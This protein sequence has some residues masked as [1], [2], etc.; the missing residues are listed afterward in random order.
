MSKTI[1][2]MSS[3]CTMHFK[4]A[5]VAFLV[6]HVFLLA[7]GASR[8]GDHDSLAGVVG[9]ARPCK[10]SSYI[11]HE[12]VTSWE[13]QL[14]VPKDKCLNM[15]RCDMLLA[16]SEILRDMALHENIPISYRNG[17]LRTSIMDQSNIALT[18][19]QGFPLFPGKSTPESF[20]WHGPGFVRHR[21]KYKVTHGFEEECAPYMEESYNSVHLGEGDVTVKLKN[22]S[23]DEFKPLHEKLDLPWT[24]ETCGETQHL[25]KSPSLKWKIENDRYCGVGRASYEMMYHPAVLRRKSMS[26]AECVDQCFPGL[27]GYFGYDRQVKLPEMVYRT[28]SKSVWDAKINGVP[29][30]INWVA[31]YPSLWTAVTGAP[32]ALSCELSFRVKR[33]DAK[34]NDDLRDALGGTVSLCDTMHEAGWDTGE[35]GVS[36]GS[37]QAV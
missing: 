7:H 21:R 6:L 1:V 25:A 36:L 2:M 31:K 23:L 12:D 18:T 8:P 35:H 16:V 32:S 9:K 17:S 24:T 28:F 30:V 3:D 22:L 19:T 4:A 26:H 37:L 13:F 34:D 11:T 33:K 5:V 29:A 27:W 14:D 10:F 20:T 15:S